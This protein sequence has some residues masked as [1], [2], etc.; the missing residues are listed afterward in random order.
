MSFPSDIATK[1]KKVPSD[2]KNLC[3]GYVRECEKNYGFRALA[4]VLTII[5]ILYCHVDEYWAKCT[6]DLFISND[7]KKV[8]MKQNDDGMNLNT[9]SR[10]YGFAQVHSQSGWI[11]KWALKMKRY[12]ILESNLWFTLTFFISSSLLLQSKP[13]VKYEVCLMGGWARVM[14]ES[15]KHPTWRRVTDDLTVPVDKADTIYIILDTKA[16]QIQ[17]SVAASSPSV[18]V[19]KII[20][21]EDITYQLSLTLHNK[22]EIVELLD[23]KLY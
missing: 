15:C 11:A 5:I 8:F 1:L 18:I 10:A 21:R 14:T 3:F 4:L 7:G 17:L 20:A 13:E 22:Q 16:Q 9:D 19:E 2:L 12:N 6:S 23:F